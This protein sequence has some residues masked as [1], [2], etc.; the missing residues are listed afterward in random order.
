MK[1]LASYHLLAL[2]LYPLDHI[3]RTHLMPPVEALANRTDLP[4][5]LYNRPPL[6]LDYRCL[7]AS[8]FI[9]RLRI[10]PAD[11]T[12]K[13]CEEIVPFCCVTTWGKDLKLPQSS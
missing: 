13:V 7:N 8:Q 2:N 11:P 1:Y 9:L 12:L 4:Q 10:L 3:T 6:I 5:Y